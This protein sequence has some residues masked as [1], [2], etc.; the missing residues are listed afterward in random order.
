MPNDRNDP[1]PLTRERTMNRQT[2]L[3]SVPVVSACQ[4]AKEPHK[5]GQSEFRER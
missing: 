4:I 1:L 2:D 5:P 3:V